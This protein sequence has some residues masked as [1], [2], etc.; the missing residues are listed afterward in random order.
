MK[1]E[2]YDAVVI[3]AGQAGV[4]LAAALADAGRRTAII[5]RTHVGGTCANDGCTPTKALVASARAAYVA[6]RSC[7]YGIDTRSV[8]VDMAEVHRRMA[9]MVEQFRAGGERRL[10]KHGVTLVAGSARYLGPRTI[11][12]GDALRIETPLSVI[13]TGG[14]PA[15]PAIPGLDTTPTLDST[16][17][18]ALEVVPEHLVVIGGGYIGCEFA[19]MFRRFGSAVTILQRGGT[20]LGG[21]DPDVAG[22]LADVLAEDG[23]EIVCHAAVTAIAPGQVTLADRAVH[24][25]HILVAT[26]RTP[27]TETLGLEAAG[28]ATTG[29]GHV[30]VTETLATTASGI[31]AAGD[32]TGEAEFTHVSYDDFRI[33]KTNLLEG[34]RATTTGRLIPYTV[35]TDPPLG[36]VGLTE[37]AAR[38][39]GY[40]VA[41][42]TLPMRAVARAIE[43]SETRGAMKAVVD[44]TTSRIL[45]VAVLGIEGG[46]IMGALQIAMMGNMPYQRLRD[47]IFAHPTLL[48]SLNNL[49]ASL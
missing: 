14:R 8:D 36:R 1:V 13:N 12:V 45:G 25:S 17:I 22:M 19:Q 30:K 49:F 2:Q 21:E 24:A 4:P 32:V 34:G 28:V 42:A 46:E 43:T 3:G 40:D 16:S 41:V 48:E 10:A 38:A 15:R 39:A 18:L 35:F 11:A 9:G 37:K 29:K 7:V 20:L 44:R 5:E 47:G 6:R 31:Y 33:L 26:G 23:V 27:N